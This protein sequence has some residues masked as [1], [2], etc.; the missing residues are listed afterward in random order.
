MPFSCV[1]RRNDS[2]KTFFISLIFL[3]SFN[4]LHL[5]MQQRNVDLIWR[6]TNKNGMTD[7]LLQRNADL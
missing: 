5:T 1:T 7:T 2:S 3:L 6:K 4:L